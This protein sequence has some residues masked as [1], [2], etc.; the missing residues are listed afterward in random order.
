MAD[1][2]L[3]I[4]TLTRRIFL[5][6]KDSMH[7]DEKWGHNVSDIFFLQHQELGFT[8]LKKEEKNPKG[9]LHWNFW[10][11]HANPFEYL[12]ISP[13][14]TGEKLICL[15]VTYLNMTI[16]EVQSLVLFCP[17]T[18]WNTTLSLLKLEHCAGIL[19][20]QYHLTIQV[21]VTVYYISNASIDSVKF[22]S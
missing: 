12:P 22:I 18:W 21:L 19:G 2:G 10:H 16:H 20:E 14:V 8:C 17:P 7:I 6:Q 11:S 13:W 4:P 5:K 3:L 15:S 1:K 9:I